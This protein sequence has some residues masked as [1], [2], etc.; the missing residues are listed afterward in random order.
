MNYIYIIPI[1]L[2]GMGVF[3]EFERT[4]CVTLKS[5]PML[6][7][8]KANSYLLGGYLAIAVSVISIISFLYQDLRRLKK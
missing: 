8:E 7:G 1:F 6:C 3:V 4:G 2:I 5:L